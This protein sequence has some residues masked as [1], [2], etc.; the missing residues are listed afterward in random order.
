FE[1]GIT[2]PLVRYTGSDPT[3]EFVMPLIKGTTFAFA[4]KVGSR[5]LGWQVGV[6]G[7]AVSLTIPDPPVQV[8]PNDGATGITPTTQF[9]AS[10]PTG[11][12]LTY[13]WIDTVG[14]LSFGITTMATSVSLPDLTAFDLALPGG[15]GFIWRVTAGSGSTI[16]G[17][18]HLSLDA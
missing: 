18:T 1:S 9:S 10:N 6:T 4:G 13:W 14:G 16:D 17:A 5:Q 12:P 3:Q 15:N 8:A 7:P 2:M 11:G